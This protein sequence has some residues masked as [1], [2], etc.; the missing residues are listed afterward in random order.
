[1]SEVPGRLVL[2]SEVEDIVG[3]V[4]SFMVRIMCIGLAASPIP[5]PPATIP[6]FL[7]A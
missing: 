2:L 3:M 1:M 4:G 5:G 6:S 7:I